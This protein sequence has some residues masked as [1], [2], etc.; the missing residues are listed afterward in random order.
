MERRRF[1]QRLAGAGALAGAGILYDSRMGWGQGQI[2]REI[3]GEQLLRAAESGDWVTVRRLLEAGADPDIV[4]LTPA[5]PLSEWDRRGRYALQRLSALGMAAEQ[6]NLDAVRLLLRFKADFN[7]RGRDGQ[8][9][10]IA[11]ARAG[12]TQ[13]ARLLL[14]S[15]A[16]PKIEQIAGNAPL[17]IARQFGGSELIRL[18]EDALGLPSYR[19]T[20]PLLLPPSNPA[21]P[22][23]YAPETE[24]EWA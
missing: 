19:R 7:K 22:R 17:R 11:A 13:A 16:D 12:Q 15:G 21:R 6:G 20:L 23:A 8:T 18:F 14:E 1:L 9:A 10:L 5:L 24:T 3:A 4:Q 2:P